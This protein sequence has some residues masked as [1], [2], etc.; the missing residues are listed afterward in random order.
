MAK[1]LIDYEIDANASGLIGA[2]KKGGKAL[3][4]LEKKAKKSGKGAATA[5]DKA[6]DRLK[7]FAAKARE[8]GDKLVRTGKRLTLGLTAPL[9][10]LGLASIKAAS[11][12][13]ESRTKSAEVFGKWQKD[14]DSWAKGSARSMGLSKR[15]TLEAAGT[16]GNLF[17]SMGLSQKASVGMSK[18]VVGLSSDLASFNNMRTDETLEKLR[19]G[20]VGEIEP[21]RQLGVSFNAADVERKAF[22]LGLVDASGTVSEAAKVQARYELILEQTTNS[23]GDFARTADGL[24]NKGRIAEAMFEDMRAEIGEHLLPIANQLLS[25]GSKALE[26]FGNLSP[27]MQKVVIALG[28]IA[29]AAGPVMIVIGSMLRSLESIRE[30]LDK[31]VTK[32][33]A[34]RE[35]WSKSG[36]SLGGTMKS[37]LKN[38]KLMAAGLTVAAAAVALKMLQDSANDLRREA[39]ELVSTLQGAPDSL[40]ELEASSRTLEAQLVALARENGGT[41]ESALELAQAFRDGKVSG[42][43]IE[44]MLKSNVIGSDELEAQFKSLVSQLMENDSAVENQK[45]NLAALGEEFD[46]TSGQVEALAREYDVD[47]AQAQEVVAQQWE[48]RVPEAT[49]TAADAIADIGTAATDTA[50]AINDDLIKSLNNLW[51]P[52]ARARNAARGFKE[53]LDDLPGKIDDVRDSQDDANTKTNDYTGIAADAAN[54]VRTKFMTALQDGVPIEEALATAQEDMNAVTNQFSDVEIPEVRDELAFW[55]DLLNKSTTPAI[56]DAKTKTGELGTEVSTRLTPFLGGL[57]TATWNEHGALVALGAVDP[58]IDVNS[59]PVRVAGERTGTLA[60]EIGGV[61]ATIGNAQAIRNLVNQFLGSIG[62]ESGGTIGKGFKTDGPVAV[63]GEGN[64]SRP[65]Y[66]IPTDPK[67]RTN[68]IDLMT[69]ASIDLGI[70]GLA[71][72]GMFGN[73]VHH[74]TRLQGE[75]AVSA[76]EMVLKALKEQGGKDAQITKRAEQFFMGAPYVWGGTSRSGSDCSGLFYGAARELGISL[77]RTASAQAA[78][79]VTSFSVGEAA[80]RYGAYLG[81]SAAGGPSGWHTARSHGDGVTVEQTR[82]GSKVGRSIGGRFNLA[83]LN[84]DNGGTLEPGL[85]LVNNAT[86]AREPLVPA[87]RGDV[88]LT[89][90]VTQNAG[91]DGEAFAHRTAKLAT[92]LLAGVA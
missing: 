76:A 75:G 88:N 81:N 3:E 70:S 64:P 46:L 50:T 34:W 80:S 21:L 35:A 82:G 92:E 39:D 9:A 77:P 37:I 23:Q 28:G 31:G 49:A 29:A 25:W 59:E 56:Q 62:L 74:G 68:A 11:D 24:A 43:A 58:S 13:N 10:A 63:V 87:K 1:T 73:I 86:G 48:D 91:E 45:T 2:A 20:L 16:F 17:T 61:A 36:R 54:A 52:A 26:M 67:Y 40:A 66:V 55:T 8:V 44:R 57:T 47:L 84:F 69:A 7:K 89:F 72:G 42:D 38:W 41:A 78:A 90:N 53:T 30:G 12:L 32:V 4:D 79:R 51:D 14:I 6:Q 85:N 60:E 27:A 5:W 33:R 19:S 83:G 15:A 65:E 18:G 22:E 71:S